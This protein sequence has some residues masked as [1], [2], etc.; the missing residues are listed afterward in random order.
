M[1]F[2]TI[3]PINNVQGSVSQIQ[4]NLGT[5]IKFTNTT[6]VQQGAQN[7]YTSYTANGFK[8]FSQ[9]VSLANGEKSFTA[10]GSA[11][12]LGD[13]IT[14]DRTLINWGSSGKIVTS[15]ALAKMIEDGWGIYKRYFL[16]HRS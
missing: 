2:T 12:K 6:A 14:R 8:G 9:C 11:N 5:N 16:F 7:I 15:Y 10:T 4:S 1:S 13:P 3:N